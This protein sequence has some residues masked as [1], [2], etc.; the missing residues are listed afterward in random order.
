MWELNESHIKHLWIC[1]FGFV[2]LVSCIIVLK[3]IFKKRLYVLLKVWLPQM[4]IIS[5]G[6]FHLPFFSARNG[7]NKKCSIQKQKKR[8][9]KAGISRAILKSASYLFKYPHGRSACIRKLWPSLWKQELSAGKVVLKV[10]SL[11]FSLCVGGKGEARCCVQQKSLNWRSSHDDQTVMRFHSEEARKP[12]P[13]C[14]HF[15]A[16]AP[17]HP[18]RRW[19]WLMLKA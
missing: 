4:S 12:Q 7:F 6:W 2:L 13:R 14:E 15:P 8:G 16:D 3:Y 18:P 11:N 17:T 5:Q 1:R 10:E 19:S 9:A